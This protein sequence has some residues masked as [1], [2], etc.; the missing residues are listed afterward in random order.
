MKIVSLTEPKLMMLVS[1]VMIVLAGVFLWQAALVWLTNQREKRI[2]QTELADM[3]RYDGFAAERAAWKS[4]CDE[5]NEIIKR[6]DDLIA[7]L[8]EEILTLTREYGLAQK[9]MAKTPVMGRAADQTKVT[10]D[11]SQ[12]SL[13]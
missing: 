2:H 11:G 7:G 9:I 5:K 1:Y 8:N 4:A 13:S 6:K 3:R 12:H 10:T